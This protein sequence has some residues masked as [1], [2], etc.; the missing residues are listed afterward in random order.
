M[1]VEQEIFQIELKIVIERKFTRVCDM[2]SNWSPL[3]SSMAEALEQKVEFDEKES[4]L[5]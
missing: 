4:H 3:Q 2:S 5:I 1:R